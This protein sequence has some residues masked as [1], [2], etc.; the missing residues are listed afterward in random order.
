V[1]ADEPGRN[2]RYRPAALRGRLLLL[3]GL[4][5]PVKDNNVGIPIRITFGCACF[6]AAIILVVVF[7]LLRSHYPGN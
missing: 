2:R 5:M 7:I 6:I 4:R 1:D 3:E